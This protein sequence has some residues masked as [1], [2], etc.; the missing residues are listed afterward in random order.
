MSL[1]KQSQFRGCFCPVRYCFEQV[2]EI[3][4][5][6]FV[7]DADLISTRWLPEFAA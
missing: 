3:R 7:R 5:A 4:G 1:K 6:G 2:R